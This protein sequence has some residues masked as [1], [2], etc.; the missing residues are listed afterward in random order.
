MEIIYILISCYILVFWLLYSYNYNMYAF[1]AKN[2]TKAVITT[3]TIIWLAALSII[4]GL[5]LGVL[6]Y[7]VESNQSVIWYYDY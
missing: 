6:I 7:V 3:N 5:Q 1:N 4:P 2:Y